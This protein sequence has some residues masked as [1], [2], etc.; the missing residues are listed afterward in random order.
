MKSFI[1][2]PAIYFLGFTL[3]CTRNL[4]GNFKMGMRTEKARLQRSLLQLRNLMGGCGTC[5]L[6]PPFFLT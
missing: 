1:V 2:N 4:K 3:Y 5:H 6:K